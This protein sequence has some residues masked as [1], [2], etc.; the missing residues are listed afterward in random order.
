MPHAEVL[1]LMKRA[2]FV[3]V[4][5]IWHEPFGRIVIEAYACG[6]PVLAT[7]MGG[8]SEIIKDGVTGW[9]VG[10]IIEE[11]PGVERHDPAAAFAA[12]LVRAF[13][14]APRLRANARAAYE[15]KYTP[16]INHSHL[17]TAYSWAMAAKMAAREV[18]EP[19]GVQ[20]WSK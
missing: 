10:P 20:P 11:R 18:A 13:D 14:E 5:S 6:T 2:A 7:R 15:A 16:E 4:P 8:L 1:D 9:L 3:V 12:G 17:M 19:M